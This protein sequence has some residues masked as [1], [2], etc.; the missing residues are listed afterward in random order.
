VATL[1]AQAAVA[2]RDPDAQTLVDAASKLIASTPL[3][4]QGYSQRAAGLYR[5]GRYKDALADTDQALKLGFNSTQ[6]RVLRANIFKLTGDDDS[7]RKEAEAMIR[8]NPDSDFAYVA[9]AKTYA[10]LGRRDDAMR[11]FDK[12]LAIKPQ[13]YIY[14]NRAQIR[15]LSD[16]ADRTADYDAALKLDP[17]DPDALAGKA[18]ILA[19]RGKYAEAADLYEQAIKA[20]PD[21]DYLSLDRAALLYKGG[22]TAEAQKLFADARAK[23]SS[24]TELNHLCWTKATAGIMLESALQDCRDALKLKPDSG[25]YLD[26][27]GMVLLKLGKL[28]EALT[29]YDQAIAKKTGADSLMGRALV[30]ARKGDRTRADA[31]A[32]AARKINVEIDAVFAAE[33]GLKL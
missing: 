24:P 12:A 11:A 22:R 21:R 5:L 15:P 18:D 16:D 7:V 20:G 9:A 28:D 27:L 13:G 31:D 29:A 23:A 33:Y 26:S 2:E 1:A 25:A 3:A 14:I 19:R 30:Y 4:A 6:V 32:T 17:N 10:A 8:E